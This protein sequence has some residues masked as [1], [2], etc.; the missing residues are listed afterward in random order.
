MPRSPTFSVARSSATTSVAASHNVRLDG[1]GSGPIYNGTITQW[2]D[3]A[4]VATNGGAKSPRQGSRPA[5]Y[6]QRAQEHHQG[7]LP[8]CVRS[9]TTEAFTYWLYQA[10]NSGIAPNGGEPDG[11]RRWRVEA[12]NIDGVA[13][14]AGMAQ[15]ID[16]TLGSIGYVEY[17]YVL[18]PGNAAIDVAQ[19]QDK[20]GQW[21]SPSLDEHRQRRR[22][23]GREGD[24]RQLRHHRR[25]WATT[26]GPSRRTAG[27]SCPRASRTRRPAKR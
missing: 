16:N 4:I 10:G 26:S 11:G 1:R 20:N 25:A 18:I 15:G 12:S 27:Q 24:A 9:G 6:S 19:L 23:R 17:S 13:N 22:R 8:R 2:S 14:N 5:R 7:P 21:L 3:P